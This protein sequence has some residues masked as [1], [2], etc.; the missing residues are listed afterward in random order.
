MFGGQIVTYIGEEALH[1]HFGCLPLW[2]H[3]YT[4]S[5]LRYR[6]GGFDDLGLVRIAC[7]RRWTCHAFYY[8]AHQLKIRPGGRFAEI[9]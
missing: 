3:L 9:H 2:E 1:E 4:P 6:E 8:L 7:E 5:C